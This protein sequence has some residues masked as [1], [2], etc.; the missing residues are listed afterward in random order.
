MRG[1]SANGDV[2]YYRVVTT[3]TPQV[4][5][6]DATGTGIRYLRWLLPDGT[7]RA[8]AD[9]AA[10]G[11]SASLWDMYLTPGQHGSR[12]RRPARTTP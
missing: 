12:S 1:R 3:G 7:V 8:E 4:W 2:D 5:R 11:S 9:I 6:L 10:D